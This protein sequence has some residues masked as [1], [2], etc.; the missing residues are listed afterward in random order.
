MICVNK[1]L[2]SISLFLCICIGLFDVEN[3]TFQPKEILSQQ[4]AAV[5]FLRFTEAML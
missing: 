4:E 1:S 5:I 2:R 3:N